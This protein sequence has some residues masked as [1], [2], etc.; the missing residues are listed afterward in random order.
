MAAMLEE[1]LLTVENERN[2]L[3]T[4]FLHMTD[5][6]VAFAGDGSIV[7]CNPAASDMLE[8]AVEDMDYDSLFGALFPLAELTKLRRPNFKEAELHIHGKFLEVYFAPFDQES[9]SG[10]MAVLHD[11]TRPAEERGDAKGIRGQRLPRAAHPPDQY[12]A[13]TPRR[14]GTPTR[15]PRR[16]P[17]ASWTSSSARRTA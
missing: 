9:G 2:K 14:C 4:L 11:V 13:A 6:V 1:N 10:V 8:R 3:D 12:P 5:G 7:H 15:S 17:G 16:S